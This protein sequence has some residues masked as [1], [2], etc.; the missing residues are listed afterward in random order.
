MKSKQILRRHRLIRTRY[1]RTN[2]ST[3]CFAKS[4][5]KNGFL[6]FRISMLVFLRRL[7]GPSGAIRLR[8]TPNERIEISLNDSTNQ[9]S[10]EV[11]DGTIDPL[12]RYLPTDPTAF[13][14]E[15]HRL[16]SAEKVTQTV[17]SITPW[18]IFGAFACAPFFVMKYNLDSMRNQPRV[19]LPV[20]KPKT[21]YQFKQVVFS[22]M[23]DILERRFPTFV[24]GVSNDYHSQILVVLIKELDTLLEKYNIDCSVCILDHRTAPDT[25][26]QEYPLASFG[27]L[28]KPGNQ[29]VDFSGAW[30]LTDLVKFIVPPSNITDEMIIDIKEREEK[31]IEFKQCM[32]RDRFVKM[33]R[34]WSIS[35]SL[36]CDSVDTAL[37]KCRK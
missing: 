34:D 29:L 27:Q 11:S 19:V 15:D 37:N 10:T 6:K 9:L 7:K 18:L 35:N 33:R 13:L 5:C 1:K 36:A 22:D 24:G 26:K 2:F 31:L 4:T 28:V 14:V 32:F 8:A 3:P 25:F 16:G 17:S 30:N 12:S 20:T 21:R 23:P